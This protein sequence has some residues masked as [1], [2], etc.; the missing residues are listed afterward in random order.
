MS[1]E[2][3]GYYGSPQI[4][5]FIINCELPFLLRKDDSVVFRGILRIL[6]LRLVYFLN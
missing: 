1:L 4:F 3:L 2:D 6:N 5:F